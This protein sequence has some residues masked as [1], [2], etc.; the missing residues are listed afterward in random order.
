VNE[1]FPSVKGTS[2]S[3]DEVALPEAF[4]GKSTLLLVGYKQNSQFDIDR[5]LLG[6]HQSGTE[7]AVYE[8]PT[9]PGMLPGLFASQ[10]DNGMRSGIPR[11]DWASVITIYDDGELVAEF[12]G[13]E[14]KVPG[15]VMLLDGEGRVRFFHDRGYS[16]GSLEK[17]RAAITE[18]KETTASR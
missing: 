2:L 10:I 7:V 4:K 5:W 15:R 14:N 17:L 16:V 18:L 8:L 13:N 9:I 11:E 1:P 3:G 12:T 6:L